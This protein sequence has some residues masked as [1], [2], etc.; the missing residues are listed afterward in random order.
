MTQAHCLTVVPSVVVRRYRGE[1]DAA[2][3]G[4]TPL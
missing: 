2:L 1:A 4:K 3:L